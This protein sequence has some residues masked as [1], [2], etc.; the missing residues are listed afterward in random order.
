MRAHSR[1]SGC[2]SG[3]AVRGSAS[4]YVSYPPRIS[5]RRNAATI[6]LHFIEAPSP[7]PATDLIRS[8]IEEIKLTPAEG[9]L[10]IELRG[11]LAGI[12]SLCSGTTKAALNGAAFVEQ[13]KMVAGIGFEPMTFRL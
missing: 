2:A 9:A 12:L 11:A 3:G 1:L 6:K 7:G 5:N 4:W 8:L 10:T 13:I